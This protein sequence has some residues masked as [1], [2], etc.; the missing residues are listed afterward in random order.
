MTVSLLR[1]R[2]PGRPAR[3]TDVELFFDLVF[4]FAGPLGDP[5]P[6]PAAVRRR[7]RGRATRRPGLTVQ[8]TARKKT[9]PEGA[10]G[11]S[12]VAV[13]AFAAFVAFLG[14]QAERRDRPGVQAG[15]PDRLAGFFAIAVGPVFDAP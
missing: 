14:L 15:N 3:V 8:K 7:P 5:D 9:A 4:V 10:A 11:R 6:R 12:V 13:N 1:E 2:T